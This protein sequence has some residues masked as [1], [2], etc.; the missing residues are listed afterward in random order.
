MWKQ[1]KKNLSF[2]QI[3]LAS[4]LS[5]QSFLHSTSSSASLLQ[6]HLSLL[7]LHLLSSALCLSFS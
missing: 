6:V 2:V 5:L 7:I 4:H 1:E 3:S